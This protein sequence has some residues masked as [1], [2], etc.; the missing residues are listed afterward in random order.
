MR[1]LTKMNS[2]LVL[3]L[4]T[5]V[6][7]LS[8][9]LF[10]VWILILPENYKA[11]G[12]TIIFS[13]ILG[14][15]FL[16]LYIIGLGLNNMFKDQI[17]EKEFKIFKVVI[18]TAF[19]T[20]FLSVCSIFIFQ[21]AFELKLQA[22]VN[23]PLGIIFMYCFIRIVGHLTIDFKYLDKGMEPKSWDFLITMFLICFIPF[24][25]MIMHS[26]MRLIQKDRIEI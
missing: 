8:F 22:I 18:I 3:L 16:W 1:N 26:H 2:F 9:F 21:I 20:T 15:Y 6:I 7:I 4:F 17:N 25:L 10:K 23:I 24:G 13:G 12:L 11:I 19:V 14:S 5:V